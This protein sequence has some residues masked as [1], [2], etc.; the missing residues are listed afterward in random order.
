MSVPDPAEH[1]AAPA[2]NDARIDSDAAKP[3]V[4]FTWPN[5]LLIIAIVLGCYLLVSNDTTGLPRYI[6]VIQALG[7]CVWLMPFALFYNVEKTAIS[8]KLYVGANLLFLALIAMLA[9]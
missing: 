1:T 8:R 4:A 3:G 2:M 9:S 5:G 7:H 6:Q